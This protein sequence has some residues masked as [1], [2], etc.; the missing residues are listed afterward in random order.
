[1]QSGLAVWL[2]RAEQFT[3]EYAL[4]E[5]AMV[6]A[7]TMMIYYGVGFGGEVY[8]IISIPVMD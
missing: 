8:M 7:L 6:V 2:A 5:S 4:P 3:T 1:M